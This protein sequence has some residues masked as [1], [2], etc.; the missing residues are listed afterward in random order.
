M[1]NEN[2]VILGSSQEQ[3]VEGGTPFVSEDVETPT[4]AEPIK[5]AEKLVPYNRFKE[6]NDELARLRKQTAVNAG[7]LDVGD[8]I[9]ISAALNGLNQREQEKLAY[10]HKITGKPLTEIKASE[11]FQLWQ[12]AYRAKLEKEELTMTPSSRQSESDRPQTLSERLANASLEEKERILSEAGLY[13][14]PRQKLDRVNIGPV[15]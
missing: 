8:Y 13:K 10:E 7:A 2:D 15:R 5:S 1:E 4:P 3:E 9:D 6:V 12:S 14:A 11:D